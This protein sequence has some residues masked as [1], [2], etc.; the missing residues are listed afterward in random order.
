[1]HHIKEEYT[2]FC[3]FLDC[4]TLE[5]GTDRLSR[6]VGNYQST[7]RNVPEERRP[8]EIHVL[9]YVANFEW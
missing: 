6:N 1:M 5:G 3:F 8:P 4:L 2:F 7:L 9:I